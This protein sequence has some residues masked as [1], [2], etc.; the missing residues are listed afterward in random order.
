MGKINVVLFD[1]NEKEAIEYMNGLRRETNIDW[2]LEV[3]TANQGRGKKFADIRRYAKY[4]TC[5]LNVFFKRRQ[6]GIII[7]WQAFYGIIF[8]FYCRLF[9]VKKE[10]RVV[11]QHF[12]FKEKKGLIGKIYHSF[13]HY[14]VSSQYIDLIITCS[15]SYVDT[16]KQEFG[17]PDE[18]VAF[19]HFGVND[20]TKWLEKN[21]LKDDGFILSVGRSNRDWDFLIKALE[22]QSHRVVICCDTLH[23]EN[24]KSNITIKNDVQG[25][26]AF[27]YMERCKCSVIPIDDGKLSSGET[28]LLQ[29]MCFGKPIIITRPS[30]LANDYI[31][32][33]INGIVIDKNAEQL[34]NA[35]D[36]LYE[37]AEYCLRIGNRARMDFVEYYSLEAH[38]KSVGRILKEKK[39]I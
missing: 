26:E 19:A 1:S 25:I 32:D 37:D 36:A 23:R 14:A 22:C 33:G 4:F 20:F 29:Q 15:R 35:V 3:V 17:L 27:K 18:K 34:I 2:K 31:T 38:A 21:D 11:I 30:S 24:V 5:P 10:N 13:V 28:V 9:H 16:L 8:A 12:I 7:G 39:M 6:Y